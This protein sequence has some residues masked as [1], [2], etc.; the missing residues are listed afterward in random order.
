LLDTLESDGYLVEHDGRFVFRSP[1]LREFW[2]R[3][4]LP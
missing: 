3:R 4:V 2:V 1:L